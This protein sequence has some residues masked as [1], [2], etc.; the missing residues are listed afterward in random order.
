[1]QNVVAVGII[2]FLIRWWFVLQ[3]SRALYRSP[4]QGAGGVA[5]DGWRGEETGASEGVT[6]PLLEG[7]GIQGPQSNAVI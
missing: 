7:M 3:Q 5:E 4:L 1:M 6:V 2:I